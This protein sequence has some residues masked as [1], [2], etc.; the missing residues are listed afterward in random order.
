MSLLDEEII[1]GQ[2]YQEWLVDVQSRFYRANYVYNA[3]VFNDLGILYTLFVLC[4]FL[5]LF[6]PILL[7]NSFYLFDKRH[8]AY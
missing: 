3:V 8:F 6:S 7:V 4:C 5:A 2:A 1:L